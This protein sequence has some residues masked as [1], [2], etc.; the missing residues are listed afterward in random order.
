MSLVL[1]LNGL[2]LC[3]CISSAHDPTAW[4]R[5]RGGCDAGCDGAVTGWTSGW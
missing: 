1:V 4:W 3:V 5:A 2:R